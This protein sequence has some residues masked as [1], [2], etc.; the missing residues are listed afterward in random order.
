LRTLSRLGILHARFAEI[1][2][3]EKTFLAAAQEFPGSPAPHMNLAN[4][5]IAAGDPQRAIEHLLIA[6]QIRPGYS[7]VTL[8]L[9][10]AHHAMGESEAATRHY[11]ELLR[12]DPDLA[13]R[14]AYLNG[15]T[16]RASS[17][18]QIQPRI[19]AE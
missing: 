19:W 1:E 7:I 6:E 17:A 3:A 13:E 10:Q 15:A 16:G 2:A 9:A 18:A 14:F 11:A 5:R 12:S 8:L 4:L